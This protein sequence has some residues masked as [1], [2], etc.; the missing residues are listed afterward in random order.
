MRVSSTLDDVPEQQQVERADQAGQPSLGRDLALYTV[1]RLGMVVGVAGVLVLL[2]APLLV[3]AAVSVIVV[4]PLSMLV[5]GGLRRRVA[6]GLAERSAER[7]ARRDHLRAQ[8]RG[9]ADADEQ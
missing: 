4:M 3:A 7:K 1:A 5:F 8:L 9:E 6:T 2:G